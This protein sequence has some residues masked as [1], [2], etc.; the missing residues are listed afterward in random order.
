MSSIAEFYLILIQ[1]D[2]FANKSLI[3]D[4]RVTTQNLEFLSYWYRK[5]R[6]QAHFFNRCSV[7]TQFA[8]LAAGEQLCC[9]C[10]HTKL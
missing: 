10:I 3:C 6:L 2:N 8:K 7:I 1:A 5:K 4:K 9:R